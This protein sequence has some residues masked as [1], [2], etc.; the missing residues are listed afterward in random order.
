MEFYIRQT[1]N[2]D[3]VE[4]HTKHIMPGGVNLNKA[5]HAILTAKGL[6][7]PEEIF[8]KLEK[9]SVSPAD[10][11]MIEEINLI[12]GVT[13]VCGDTRYSLDLYKGTIF[14]WDEVLPAVL[15]IIRDRFE[16]D[17]DIEVLSRSD[18]K[19]PERKKEGEE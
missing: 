4:I 18:W 15:E 3:C 13:K 12:P 8:K 17:D 14:K 5:L 6:P 19:M 2:Q 11:E 16:P 9:E 10:K 1:D 7:D